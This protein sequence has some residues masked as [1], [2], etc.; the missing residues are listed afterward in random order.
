MKSGLRKIVNS[1]A[2]NILDRCNLSNHFGIADVYMIDRYLFS[3]FLCIVLT[4]A[5]LHLSE[6]F[7]TARQSSNSLNGIELLYTPVIYYWRKF[8]WVGSLTSE[9]NDCWRGGIEQFRQRC[10]LKYWGQ[11][12]IY[13][14]SIDIDSCLDL[15]PNGCSVAYCVLPE[16]ESL[17]ICMDMK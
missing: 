9:F 3:S 10:T 6:V 8:I 15:L 11:I 1:L 4:L 14:F 2:Y 5:D 13:F 7:P 16:M 12:R 17:R